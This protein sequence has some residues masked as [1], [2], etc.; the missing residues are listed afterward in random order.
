LET[1]WNEISQF[2]YD[3]LDTRAQFI[4]HTLTRYLTSKGLRKDREGVYAL[5]DQDIWA[6]ENGIAN[7]RYLNSKSLSTLIYR[8]I[9]EVHNYRIGNNPQ[10]NSLAQRFLFWKIGAEIFTENWLY[11]T[12]TGDVQIAFDEKYQS[13]SFLIKNKYQ[14]RAH[15]QFLTMGITFGG[16]GLIYFLWMLFSGF[17]VRPNSS[18]YLFVGSFIIMIVSMLDEDT[19]ETQFGITYA[20]FFYF[21]FLFHQPLKSELIAWEDAQKGII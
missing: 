16:I 2:P 19:F 6:I 12:G 21:L 8:Y 20:L 11:G 3:S 4:N 15:N 5:T 1:S 17:T 18:S 13:L 14:L 9:W 10:G 7:V